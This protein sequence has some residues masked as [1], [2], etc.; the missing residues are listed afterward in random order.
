MSASISFLVFRFLIPDRPKAFNTEN[1]W[2]M[3]ALQC[4][5]FCLDYASLSLSSRYF[6]HFVFLLCVELRNGWYVLIKEPTE[7]ETNKKSQKLVRNSKERAK[8]DDCSLAQM[9]WTNE[10]S[11]RKDEEKITET[12][13][14]IIQSVVRCSVSYTRKSPL[15]DQKNEEWAEIWND[16]A[17]AS[18]REK[19][20]RLRF[21]RRSW[22]RQQ[23]Q[24]SET[25]NGL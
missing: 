22:R 5:G 9:R 18:E 17:N 12:E 21:R 8:E 15:R 24:R 10:W 6:F 13:N 2:W 19:L 7:D 23:Q 14:D 4:I 25:E 16:Q 1:L 3:R 20:E 11:K